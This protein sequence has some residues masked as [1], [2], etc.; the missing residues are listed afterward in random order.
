MRKRVVITGLGCVCPVGNTVNSSWKNILAGVSGVGK[1]THFDASGYKSAIAAEVKDID[2]AEVLG[3]KD[4]RRLDRFA[5]LGMVAALEALEHSRLVISE[6]NRDRIG[7]LIGSGI[8]GIGTIQEQ[9]LVW[10]DRGPERVSPFMVPM[11]IPDSLGGVLAINLGIKGPNY[12]IATAC[13]TGNNAIGEAVEVIRR[14]QADVMFAG[15]AEAAI[16]P[17]SVAA[18]ASMTALS[19]RNNDPE[20]ASRPFELNRDGFVM[21]EGAGVLVLESLEHA[22]GRGAHILAEMIGYGSNND[23]HHITAPAENGAG[24]VKCMKMALEDAGL[25]VNDIDYINAH[26]TSTPLNDKSET[27]AIKAVFGK[28]AYQIPVSSTKSMTGHMMGAT[29]AV[30]AVFCIKAIHD[31]VMPPTINY[32]VPDPVCDLDY[33]PNEKREKVLNRVMS[34]SF[35]FGGHNATIIL[36]RYPMEAV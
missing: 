18:M 20:H 27:A 34:N 35:G 15:G 5:Q 33:V 28:Q 23:A 22:Q 7:V 14:G 6:E 17:V 8:G 24:A 21:G 3:R 1:I 26:G 12:A 9:V 25:D 19:V 4:A 11:I 13:A 10:M 16:V 29:G 31:N 36:G 30:E 32:E 2:V